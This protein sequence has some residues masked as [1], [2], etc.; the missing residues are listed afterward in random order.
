MLIVW[1][2]VKCLKKL[3]RQNKGNL[4]QPLKSKHCNI[5]LLIRALKIENF[6]MQNFDIFLI[7]SQNI[8]RV[9]TFEPR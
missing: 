7:F 2:F 5:H 9:Y 8:D 6:H 1:M 4:V 3:L